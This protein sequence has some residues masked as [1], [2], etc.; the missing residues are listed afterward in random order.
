[1]PV[2]VPGKSGYSINNNDF[3]LI[4]MA[5]LASHQETYSVIIECPRF[6]RSLAF[7]YL[8]RK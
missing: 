5:F 4:V 7:L 1:M 2:R 3:C 6:L 8:E